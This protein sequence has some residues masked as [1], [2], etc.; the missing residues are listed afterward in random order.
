MAKISRKPIT[1]HTIQEIVM[2]ILK[3][4]KYPTQLSDGR[5]P[6]GI[7]QLIRRSR[8]NISDVLYYANKDDLDKYIKAR[9]KE[10]RIWRKRDTNNVI[11][12]S[13]QRLSGTERPVKT[14]EAV[15]QIGK[16]PLGNLSGYLKEK[17]NS[18]EDNFGF[19][20]FHI[21]FLTVAVF[22]L[23]LVQIIDVLKD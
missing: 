9:Y 5:S 17:S 21:S 18:A 16:V 14:K 6:I 8:I 22:I 7:E 2:Y 3:N 19:L 23:I 10:Y 12:R 4:N 13:T 11:K 1:P 15:I 20:K